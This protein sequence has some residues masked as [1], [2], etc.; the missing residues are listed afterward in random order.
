[1]LFCVI[2]SMAKNIWIQIHVAIFV[3]YDIKTCTVRIILSLKRKKRIFALLNTYNFWTDQKSLI[4]P[5][6][7]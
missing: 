7:F 6:D 2:V 5:S 1:M 3:D 4:A